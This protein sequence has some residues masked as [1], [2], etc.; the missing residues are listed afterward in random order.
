MNR[1]CTLLLFAFFISNFV[2]GQGTID[3]M[4][5]ST[6][7]AP[8]GTA[9]ISNQAQKQVHSDQLLAVPGNDDC[10]NAIALTVGG[11]CVTGTTVGA[12]TQ[13]GE[14]FSCQTADESVW[15]KF[16]ATDDSMWVQV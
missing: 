16:V 5:L 9:I 12:T 1:V 7:V 10:A 15:Y 13:S 6:D 3:K 11:A 2:A 8:S 4:R 14:N